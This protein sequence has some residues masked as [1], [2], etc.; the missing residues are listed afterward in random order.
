MRGS[1]V[2]KTAAF[3]LGIPLKV[4]A[5]GVKKEL[6]CL[7]VVEPR[8]LVV[9]EPCSLIQDQSLRRV[10]GQSRG[11]HVRGWRRKS[12]DRAPLLRRRRHR[13]ITVPLLRA[14]SPLTRRR[15]DEAREE[16]KG[17]RAKAE[18][19]TS[20]RRR[21]CRRTQSWGGKGVGRKDVGERGQKDQQ[22]RRA[23]PTPSLPRW[24]G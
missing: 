13:G 23:A 11:L 20:G 24:Q 18:Y 15:A 14:R 19:M 3:G 21:N 1:H 10:C 8:A 22:Q 9:M 17:R 5:G 7:V 16:W 6:V 12:M 2:N 4:A